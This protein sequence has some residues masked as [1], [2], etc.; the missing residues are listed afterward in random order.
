MF[1]KCEFCVK[2]DF[3]NV[4]LVKNEILKMWILPK[5]RFW[6][7]E[8]SKN[9]DFQSV[10][11]WTK[12][13]FLPLCVV[14]LSFFSWR[15]FLNVYFEG[16]N[17]KFQW[18]WPSLRLKRWWWRW[19]SPYGPPPWHRRSCHVEYRCCRSCLAAVTSGNGIKDSRRNQSSGSWV[20]NPLWKWSN[21]TW[22]L[23]RKCGETQWGKTEQF[24]QKLP[25]I[26]CLKMWILWKMWF[27][28]CDFC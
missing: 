2:W 4:N 5:M 25:R 1:E 9:R 18:H 28:K 15:L 19:C 24:I 3:E 11:F 8:F 12:C 16:F 21:Q 22:T 17:L 27:W 23:E 10:N 26:W 14:S 20:Q 7:C 6:K 13:T